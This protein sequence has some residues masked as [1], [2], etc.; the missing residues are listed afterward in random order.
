[1]TQKY[2]K[3][4]KINTRGYLEYNLEQTIDLLSRVYEQTEKSNKV[5][6]N[7]KRGNKVVS[8]MTSKV[9]TVLAKFD[10]QK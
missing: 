1:M 7:S 4:K 8:I 2:I 9:S 10:S 5:H 3:Q 6:A